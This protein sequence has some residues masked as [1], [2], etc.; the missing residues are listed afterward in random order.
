M[1]QT[2]EIFFLEL[3][4]VYIN[5]GIIWGLPVSIAAAYFLVM[6]FYKQNSAI[7]PGAIAVILLL[8]EIQHFFYQEKA[9]AKVDQIINAIKTPGPSYVNTFPDS[10]SF[11][12]SI[13]S[14][15]V[16]R[17]TQ[18]LWPK[19]RINSEWCAKGCR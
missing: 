9:T 3:Y 15:F 5:T 14:F 1:L 16:G 4:Q 11:L 18:R 10:L 19:G 8:I 7:V 13:F 2:L 17:L 12:E 6:Q